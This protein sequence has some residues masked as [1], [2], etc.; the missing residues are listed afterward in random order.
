MNEGRDIYAAEA[1]IRKEVVEQL[2]GVF[3]RGVEH[4]E[5]L[6]CALVG[7]K[8][9][10]DWTPSDR[11]A[12]YKVNPPVN[13]MTFLPP[14]DI[15]GVLPRWATI[16]SED[17]ALYAWAVNDYRKM[18]EHGEIDELTVIALMQASQMLMGAQPVAPANGNG[19]YA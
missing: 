19:A 15:E 12:T 11:L 5:R 4:F 18:V 13:P 10:K 1:R 7:R 16:A 3:E 8:A 6:L 2:D 17:Q 14:P 9:F